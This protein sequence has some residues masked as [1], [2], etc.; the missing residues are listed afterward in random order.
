MDELSQLEGCL[1]DDLLVAVSSPFQQF[2]QQSDINV[3]PQVAPT[4][5]VVNQAMA[6]TTSSTVPF[7][8]GVTTA[9][10]SDAMVASVPSIPTRTAVVL[11]AQPQPQLD[12]N[13]DPTLLPTPLL[14]TPL[15]MTPTAS[16]FTFD[17]ALAVEPVQIKREMVAPLAPLPPQS[18][19][20]YTLAADPQLADLFSASNIA[21][22]AAAAAAA[23][24]AS[25]FTSASAPV[26]GPTSPSGS[27]YSASSSAPHSAASTTGTTATAKTTTNTA[28]KSYR[29]RIGG[30]IPTLRT[31]IRRG[32]D[33]NSELFKLA[34]EQN[35]ITAHRYRQQA[36]SKRHEEEAQLIVLAARNAELTNTLNALAAERQALFEQVKLS[37]VARS[38]LGL[39]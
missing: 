11:P 32:E 12:P 1:D 34:R 36:S 4:T 35:R 6:T 33:P 21:A 17:S 26:S 23:S 30:P 2:L 3:L 7:S 20:A 14:A 18:Y 8:T 29:G 5:T 19:N 16:Y 38:I 15:L 39:P 13:F 28:R 31:L 37:A 10:S 9:G 24:V 27:H 22:A 25:E